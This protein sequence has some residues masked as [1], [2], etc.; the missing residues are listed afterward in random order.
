M[1]MM[2]DV[3]LP[4]AHIRSQ[5]AAAIDVIVQVARL[6]DGRR[7]IWEVAAVEGTRRGEPV[8]ESLFRFRVREGA[9]GRFEATG[10][11]PEVH[12]VLHDRGED[13]PPELFEAGEDVEPLALATGGGV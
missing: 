10:V 8:V 6:R 9:R 1:A 4:A 11:V 12:G 3:A 5:V 2:S 7:V 13:V